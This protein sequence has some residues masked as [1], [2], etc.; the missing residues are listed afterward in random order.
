MGGPAAGT[1]H[2]GGKQCARLVTTRVS[3]LLA[4]RGPAVLVDQMS[5]AQARAV[6]AAGL[7]AARGHPGPPFLEGQASGGK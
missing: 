1:V 3:E 6:L 5:A 7:P 2:P 4:G